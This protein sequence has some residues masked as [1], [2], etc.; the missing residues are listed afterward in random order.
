MRSCAQPFDLDYLQVATTL[1][2][3]LSQ[4]YARV[5]E[6]TSHTADEC[7][8]PA[9]VEAFIKLDGRIKVGGRACA[10]PAAHGWPR[11]H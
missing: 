9:Y 8:T 1:C 3:L 10:R 2:E 5:V 4:L 6:L 7:N 11:P